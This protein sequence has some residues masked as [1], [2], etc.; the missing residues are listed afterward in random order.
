MWKIFH[1]GGKISPCIMASNTPGVCKIMRVVKRGIFFNPHFIS[2]R[3]L[4]FSFFACCATFDRNTFPVSYSTTTKPSSIIVQ[5]LLPLPFR[6]PPHFNTSPVET[7]TRVFCVSLL[8]IFVFP[9]PCTLFV[10]ITVIF[11]CVTVRCWLY[12]IKHKL[13]KYFVNR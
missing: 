12:F 3:P 9:P 6:V 1:N 10:H 7:C 5:Y 4:K 2:P 13:S 8:S 11:F